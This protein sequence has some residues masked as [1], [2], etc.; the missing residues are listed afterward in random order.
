MGM[1]FWLQRKMRSLSKAARSPGSDL[2]F[3]KE[4]NEELNKELNK[5]LNEELNKELGGE[6]Q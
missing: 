3:D 6:T 4:L 5:E 2:R 1:N